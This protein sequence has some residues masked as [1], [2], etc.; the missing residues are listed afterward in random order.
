MFPI[1]L[2]KGK[3]VSNY[4]QVPFLLINKTYV[5]TAHANTNYKE[6]WDRYQKS[7]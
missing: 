1:T 2:P 4:L 6:K 3:K 5:L 7:N